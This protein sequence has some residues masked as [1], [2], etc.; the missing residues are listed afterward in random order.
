MV[1]MESSAAQKARNSIKII[2]RE[3]IDI[4]V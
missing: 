2:S 3:V 4:C 1:A